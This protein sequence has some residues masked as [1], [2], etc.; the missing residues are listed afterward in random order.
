MRLA[1]RSY[2]HELALPGWSMTAPGTPPSTRKNTSLTMIAPTPASLRHFLCRDDV[3]MDRPGS[4]G[5]VAG[6]ETRSSEDI[7]A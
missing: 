2:S 5:A 4:I 6:R 3:E 1:D 7:A